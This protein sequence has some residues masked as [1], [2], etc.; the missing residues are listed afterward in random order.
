MTDSLNHA[1][2]QWRDALTVVLRDKG[3]L[4]LLVAAPVLY[5]FFYPWFYATQVVTQV[6][7]AVV[8]LDHSSLSR[9]ITRLAEADPNIAVTLVTGDEQEARQ[10]LW[11]GA[12]GGYAVL[13]ADLQRE[14]FRSEAAVVNVQA[15]AA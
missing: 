13:P 3:V 7:V 2:R 9:Q 1:L 5:G 14:V 8:D 4:L 12:I 11:S 10:A 15:N 6:P